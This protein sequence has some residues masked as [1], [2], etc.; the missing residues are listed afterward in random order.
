MK[1]FQQK[2]TP[3]RIIKIRQTEYAVYSGFLSSGK[4]YLNFLSNRNSFLNEQRRGILL[5]YARFFMVNVRNK[6]K[7]VKKEKDTFLKF[8]LPFKS[9]NG[10]NTQT[11]SAYFWTI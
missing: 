3:V 5:P 1:H 8:C 2:K 11:R 10:A 4:K 7:Q 9:D 6:I